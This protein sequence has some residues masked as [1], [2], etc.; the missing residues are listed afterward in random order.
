MAAKDGKEKRAAWEV[1]F[2]FVELDSVQRKDVK[3]WDESFEHT[4][5][6]LSNLALAGGKISVSFD[7]R[8]DTFIASYTEKKVEGGRRARCLSA[9]APGMTDAM[10]VLAYK[11][12]IVLGGDLSTMEV[13]AEARNQWG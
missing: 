6:C 3:V 4:D 1:D 13:Q 2:V 12:E 9:R 5:K 8:N 11:I 7:I 10:R